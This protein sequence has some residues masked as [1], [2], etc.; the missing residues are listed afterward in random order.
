VVEVQ[1][2]GIEG[3]N[4]T[5][6]TVNGQLFIPAG[7][8]AKR[9]EDGPA[10]LKL[11]NMAVGDPVDRW[12]PYYNDLSGDKMRRRIKV[13]GDASSTQLTRFNELCKEYFGDRFIKTGLSKDGDAFVR[14]KTC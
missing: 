8:P 7:R 3:F 1:V 12:H 10:V 5:A 4:M 2:K 6:I 14:L 11:Y 13:M 9:P